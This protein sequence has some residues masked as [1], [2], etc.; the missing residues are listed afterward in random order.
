MSLLSSKIIR[1]F[2]DLPETNM[3]SLLIQ[4]VIA[5]AMVIATVFIHLIGLGI[6]VRAL[7]APSWH[8]FLERLRPITLLLGASVGIFAIHTVEIWSFALLY[9]LLGAAG[10]FEQSLYFSTVTY[11]TIGY[12]DVLV[13]QSWRILGAIEGA[14]GVIMLGWSTAFLVS[15]LAQSKLL[16]H[17]W[18]S[19]EP[20]SER[21]SSNQHEAG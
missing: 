9:L 13:A 7:R 19:A 16:K 8:P 2:R 17:D 3:Y 10:D 20:T 11:A 12:G 1:W 6:L 15:L 18:L 14:A 5:S 21:P 4:L